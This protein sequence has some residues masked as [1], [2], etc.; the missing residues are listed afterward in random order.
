MAQ[1]FYSEF[2]QV[3]LVPWR[4]EED[5]CFLYAGSVPKRQ[6]KWWAK[7]NISKLSPQI[8]QSNMPPHL[9]RDGWIE[10]CRGAEE[11]PTNQRYHFPYSLSWIIQDFRLQ[12]LVL[13]CDTS[14]VWTQVGCPPGTKYRPWPSYLTAS[15]DLLYLTAIHHPISR[16]IH[17]L[18]Q[19]LSTIYQ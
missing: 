19:K 4:V 12:P 10:G 2:V 5:S 8:Y 14:Q 3:R 9:H 18:S 6:R 17:M 11:F 15:P 16:A 7:L 13:W 1:L